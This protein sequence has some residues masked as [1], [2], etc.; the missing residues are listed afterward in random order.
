M[1]PHPLQLAKKLHPDQNKDDPEAEKKFQEVSKAY[2]VSYS[3]FTKQFTRCL[4]LFC[5]FWKSHVPLQ[6]LK[7]DEKRS[8]YDQV[9]YIFSLSETNTSPCIHLHSLRLVLVTKTILFLIRF[10]KQRECFLVIETSPS[11]T[12]SIDCI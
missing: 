6:I 3:C 8:V 1:T 9:R 12:H 4:S 10:T 2:E 11:Q 5:V 7:D